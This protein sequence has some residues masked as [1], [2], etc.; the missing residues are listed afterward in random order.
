MKAKQEQ[1][2]AKREQWKKEMRAMEDR[3]DSE[4][5]ALREKHVKG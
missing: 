4:R 3:H 1:R 2:E 5:K